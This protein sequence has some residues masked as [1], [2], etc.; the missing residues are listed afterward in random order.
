MIETTV[1]RVLRLKVELSKEQWN[2]LRDLSWQAM[3]YKNNFIRAKLIQALGFR[4]DQE[5]AQELDL[6]DA[7]DKAGIEKYIRRFEKGELSG[8][9]YG[10]IEREVAKEWKKHGATVLAGG[11]LPQSRQNDSLSIRG[12]AEKRESGVRL[13]LIGADEFAADIAVQAD[14]CEGGCWMRIKIAKGIEKDWLRDVLLEMV[15]GTTPIRKGVVVFK[16]KR[17]R[18][19]LHLAYEKPV[20][21]PHMG[22][23]V[24][25]LSEHDGRVLL[26]SETQTV[27]YTHHRAR[28]IAMKEAHDGIRRRFYRQMGRHKHS[29]RKKQRWEEI[30]DFDAWKKTYLHSWSCELV[31]WCA[32][33]GIGRITFLLVGGDWPADILKTYVSYKAEEIGIATN[34]DEDSLTDEATARTAKAAVSKKRKEAKKIGEATRTLANAITKRRHKPEPTKPTIA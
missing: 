8:A 10:A 17:G 28:I 12:H 16:P 23:R 32:T 22:Q 31:N 3:R 33:Q 5:K 9:V 14:K 27:D 4:L 34:K 7:E 20:V 11:P 13:E 29:A 18:A 15:A 26:R 6:D 21:I 1:N 24:A 30:R 2:R 19:F 25:T